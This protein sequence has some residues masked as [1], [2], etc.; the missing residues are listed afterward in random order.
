MA[1]KLKDLAEKLGM[2]LKALKAKIVELGFEVKPRATSI[3]DDVAELV[4]EELGVKEEEKP[5]DVAEIYDEMIA[6]EREKEI[7]KS[8]RKKT[9]GKDPKAAAKKREA[10]AAV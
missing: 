8:Q 2:D 1:T 4:S 6:Q 5:A 7:V 10:A 9:A 3:E